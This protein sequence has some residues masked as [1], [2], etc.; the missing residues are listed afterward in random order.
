MKAAELEH[1]SSLRA[2]LGGERLGERGL[3][4]DL[5]LGNRVA[6]H[7]VRA[8]GEP[9][10]PLVRIGVGEAFPIMAREAT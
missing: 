2:L 3:L 10:R 6:V 1:A 9:E 8:V 5:L 4:G 7:L